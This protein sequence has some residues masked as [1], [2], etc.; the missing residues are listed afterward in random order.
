M[1]DRELAQLICAFRIAFP[2][3]G[4][5]LSTRERAA[6]RDVLASLGVTMMSA[7]SHTEPGGYTG[8]GRGELH[9]T[10]R[11]R[12]VAPEFQENDDSLAT[13][14]FEISDERSPA[15]V[16]EVLR[17]RGVE[18]VWKDWDPALVAH[19]SLD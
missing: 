11:G 9:R 17:R 5:V 15:Q 16:S 3:I 4:I 12:I 19:E 2:Q 7:G 6:L 10:V 8:Q 18:S 1:S 14:Q 13:G